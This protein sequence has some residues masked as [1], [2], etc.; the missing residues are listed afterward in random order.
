[1]VAGFVL[2]ATSSAASLLVA[3]LL[4]AAS[5][6]DIIT[7]RSTSTLAIFINVPL[8]LEI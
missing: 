3:I 2:I 5:A 6:P 4:S 7:A 1:V 8:M